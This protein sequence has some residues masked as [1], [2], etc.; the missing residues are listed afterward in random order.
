M[1]YN[2]NT[3]SSTNEE[4]QKEFH[5]GDLLTVSTG[6]LYSP[7]LILGTKEFMDYLFSTDVPISMVPRASVLCRP[8]ILAQFPWLSEIELTEQSQ[9][10]STEQIKNW[11]T[12]QVSRYGE[13]HSV[14]KLPSD[15]K[16]LIIGDTDEP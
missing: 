11:I 6:R 5:L 1:S 9:L 8:F 14:K 13:K 16:S 7:K 12:S 4:Q 3:K 10:T 15:I 2:N